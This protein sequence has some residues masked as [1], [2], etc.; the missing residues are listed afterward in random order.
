MLSNYANGINALPRSQ[1]EVQAY[2]AETWED[3]ARSDT[4]IKGPGGFHIMNVLDRFHLREES[5]PFGAGQIRVFRL[6]HD[7]ETNLVIW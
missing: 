6:E 2:I 1:I 5:V 3:F 7:T 4:G